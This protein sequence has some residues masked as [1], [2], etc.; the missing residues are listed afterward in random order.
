M[1]TEPLGHDLI[2]GQSSK[3][4]STK[5]GHPLN[6]ARKLGHRLILVPVPVSDVE[7]DAEEH[8]GKDDVEKHVYLTDG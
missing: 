7:G 3:A 6:D 4:S 8:V 1:S 5:A 2:A